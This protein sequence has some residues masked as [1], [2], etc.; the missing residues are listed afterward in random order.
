MAGTGE[1]LLAHL[2][3]GLFCPSCRSQ[4]VLIILVGVVLMSL[5]DL[6]MTLQYLLHFG[7]L[8]SN[9]LARAMIHHGSPWVLAAWKLCTLMLAV[10]IL[11][12]ARRRLSAELGT[13]FCCGVMAWLTVRWIDY[14]DQMAETA[15]DSQTLV[16]F[17]EG[18]WVTLAPGG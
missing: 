1:S 5:G 11:V 15:R 13:L 6:Y 7:M 10:G 8:E 18:R 17:D 14:S 12:F 16:N 9:P 2:R 4:R 3:K